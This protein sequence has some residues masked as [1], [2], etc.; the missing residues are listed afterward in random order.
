MMFQPANQGISA[1]GLQTATNAISLTAG[2]IAAALYGNI[3]VKII[4]NNVL[5]E[6]FGFPELT[7]T[8]GK[9]LFSASVI[10]YWSLAFVIGSA[11]P[12][13]S[14][15]SSLIAAVCIFRA[16]S[17]ILVNVVT[18]IAVFSE[19]TYTF[20]PF[21]ILG[22]Y[23][24][25]DANKGDREFDINRPNAHRVD[26]WKDF[27]RWRRGR[28]YRLPHCVAELSFSTS[29]LL[30]VSK[31]FFFNLWNFLLVLA[32]ISCATLSAYSSIKSIITA[33]HT[34]GAASSFGCKSPLNNAS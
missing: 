14:N 21:M 4:Y 7:S 27:S 32:C 5:V 1:Y 10:V 12:Q 11:V 18:Y 34:S 22:F 23:A 26:T 25:V 13:F 20:P 30:T 2:L 24:Q 19:F 8:R 9:Y 15:I 31:K 3:G 28:T 17:Y 6:L 29:C 16:F 33:F